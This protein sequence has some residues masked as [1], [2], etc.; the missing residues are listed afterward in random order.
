MT[1]GRLAA[2][3]P[4]AT[5]NTSLYRCNIDNT[6]S[7]VLTATNASG[8]GVTYRAAIR[9]YDQILTMNGDE[10]ATTNN[11]EFAKGNP[12]STYKLKV[13][14]GIAFADATPGADIVSTSGSTA[15]LL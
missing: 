13:T 12:I 15:K 11:L 10:G 9:D 8:S 5:T 2:A 6:A 14:P 3:K 4:G 1:A 7:T